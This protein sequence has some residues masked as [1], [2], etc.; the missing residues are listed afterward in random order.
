MDGR[1]WEQG[2]RGVL[3]VWDSLACLILV[4]F[5]NLLL[6]CLERHLPGISEHV[7]MP[8]RM[9]YHTDLL[10]QL[11]ALITINR[12]FAFIVE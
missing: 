4:F 12:I 9:N 3:F 1:D 2:K 7:H 10:D 11:A 6:L 5:F 8:Y